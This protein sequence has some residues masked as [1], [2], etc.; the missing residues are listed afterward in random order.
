MKYS[1]KNILFFC[2]TLF[3]TSV[4]SQKWRDF[5]GEIYYD[6]YLINK[7]EN[8]DVKVNYLTLRVKGGFVRIDTHSET[9]GGQTTIR[10]LSLKKSYVLLKSEEDFWAIQQHDD[11]TKVAYEFKKQLKSR[12]ING[13]KIKRGI[14]K[15]ED[16]SEEVWYFPHID[17]IYL[18]YN[19]NFP[20]LLAS[21]NVPLN[22]E[23]Y[24]LYKVVK[25]EEKII[26]KKLFE[27]PSVFKI[28][29][30]DEFILKSQNK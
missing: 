28:I 22:S 4:F 3:F 11:T 2:F 23:E 26:D 13:V 10:N 15:L 20:G 29:T 6:V 19:S 17:P 12:K 30:M 27:I 7:S 24:L 1:K 14:R 9:F 5:E 25:I 18:H 16:V 8:K 21:Y